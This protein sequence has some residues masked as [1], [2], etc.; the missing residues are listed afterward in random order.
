MGRHF[1]APQ[2]LG[3]SC[4]ATACMETMTTPRPLDGDS[5]EAAAWLV[6]AARQGWWFNGPSVRCPEHAAVDHG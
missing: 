3:F 1:T 4:D 2:F 6:E 5:A